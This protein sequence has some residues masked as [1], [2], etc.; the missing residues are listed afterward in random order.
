[1][2]E[3]CSFH[4]NW[5]SSKDIKLDRFGKTWMNSYTKHKFQSPFHSFVNDLLRWLRQ[6]QQRENHA[7]LL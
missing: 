4:L 3:I 7:D 2:S 5:T 1:M 6:L